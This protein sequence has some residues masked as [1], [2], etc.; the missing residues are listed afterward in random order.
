MPYT[1]KV[2]GME[3]ISETLS[4]LKEGAE[5]IA[6]MALYDGAG[7]MAD[8]IRHS[9]DKIT[10]APFVYA[11]GGNVRLPSPEEKAIVVEAGA[12]IAKFS[13]NGSEVDTSIGYRNSGYAFLAGRRKPIPL[14]VNSI[15]SGTSFMRKQPFIR[16]AAS[17]GASKSIEAM[18]AKIEEAVAA[19]TKE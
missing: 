2:D 3:Q 8:E 1:M 7:V 15:N 19:I 5:G 6:A 9:A 18:K 11:S 17:S 13:K 10:T 12:G 16:K 4:S 14:I